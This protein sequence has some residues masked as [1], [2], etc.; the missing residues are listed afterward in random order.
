MGTTMWS[1]GSKF[2]LDKSNQ[3]MAYEKIQELFKK[4][5]DIRWYSQS[6]VEECTNFKDVMEVCNWYTNYDDEGNCI[7]IEFI[8]GNYSDDDLIF[9]VIAPYVEDDSYIEMRDETGE[10][11]RWVFKNNECRW[12]Y[13]DY[14]WNY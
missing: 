10:R 13:P 4:K 1:R 3:Q 7:D 9:E 8:D 2:R 11:W 12:V 5:G 6:E 14:I